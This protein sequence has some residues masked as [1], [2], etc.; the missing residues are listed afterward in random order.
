MLLYGVTSKNSRGPKSTKS[1]YSGNLPTSCFVLALE[2]CYF[3]G[4][5]FRCDHMTHDLA[6]SLQGQNVDY[7]KICSGSS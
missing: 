7:A 6:C 1:Y 5:I 2:S 4:L 3:D